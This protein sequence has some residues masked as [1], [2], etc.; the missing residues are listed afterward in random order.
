MSA[1]CTVERIEIDASL[2][3]DPSQ[4]EHAPEVFAAVD[5][6]RDH[7]S[8]WFPWVATT[9]TEEDSRAFL[10]SVVDQR[11]AG[12]FCSMLIR[13]QGRLVG[14]VGLQE[15]APAHR[16]AEIGYWLR[17][18]AQGRGLMTRAVRALVHHGFEAH[19]LNRIALRAAVVNGPSRAVARRVGFT[20]EGVLREVEA[21]P[22][23]FVDLVL[24]SMLRREWEAGAL[25]G[26][27][28]R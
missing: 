7:L 18:D 20:E 6:N 8:T 16:S 4:V 25:E 1:A 26:A 23:G 2:S 11:E 3:L 10:R 24:H 28:S 19:D 12:E 17:A 27:A 14:I 9:R 21:Y 13:E 15:F 5:A 22:G